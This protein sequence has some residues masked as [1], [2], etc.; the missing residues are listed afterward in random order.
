MYKLVTFQVTIDNLQHIILQKEDIIQRLQMLARENGDKYVQN[1][2]KLAKKLK[3][4][5]DAVDAKD[6]ACNMYVQSFFS[7]VN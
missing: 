3:A 1:M 5:Q 2:T 6:G 4:L 7:Q